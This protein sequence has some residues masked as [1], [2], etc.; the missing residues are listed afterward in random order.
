MKSL[1]WRIVVSLLVLLASIV[2]VLP[3]LPGV[4]GSSLGNLL[5]DAR[6]SLGLDLKGG[7]HLTLGVEVDKAV[8]NSL[9]LT[10]QEL[11]AQASEKGITVLRS[12]LTP[13][14]RLEFLLPR[15]EQRTELQELLSKDFPQLAVDSP[16]QVEGGGLRFTAAFTPAAKA[17]I[18]EMAL[19]QA[20][21]TIRN[22]IDQ[23]G[24][25]EPDIARGN[26]RPLVGPQNGGDSDALCVPILKREHILLP[27][28]SRVLLYVGFC[29]ENIL[30][31]SR[32]ID[33]HAVDGAVVGIS[34]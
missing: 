15:A 20:V 31:Q 23:F 13:D 30:R 9:S 5:P 2:Y 32:I 26:D 33:T 16:T 10:G 3:S 27:D 6:I 8:S 25:A 4:G 7:M 22:R 28:D 24:V 18:E 14:N 12:R 1:S 19:D 17:K 29:L 11:R 34:E 21:R